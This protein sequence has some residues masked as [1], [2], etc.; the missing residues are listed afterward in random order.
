[1]SVPNWQK[2]QHDFL[3]H[4]TVNETFQVGEKETILA[5]PVALFES[6]TR[7]KCDNFSKWHKE[8]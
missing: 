4:T 7:S 8:K 2:V 3:K 1:M 5:L 6:T